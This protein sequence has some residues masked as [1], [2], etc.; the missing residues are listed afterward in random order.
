MAAASPD[1]PAIERLRSAVRMHYLCGG[2]ENMGS[3]D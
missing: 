3:V 1:A 2:C